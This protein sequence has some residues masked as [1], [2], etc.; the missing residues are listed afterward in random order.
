MSQ[1]FENQVAGGKA[2]LELVAGNISMEEMRELA[3]FWTAGYGVVMKQN[4]TKDQL[5]VL[6][7]LHSQVAE[8]LCIP[9]NAEELVR[10]I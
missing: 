9:Q 2:I 6:R 3:F 5:N 1:T 10:K 7:D 4:L 8:K